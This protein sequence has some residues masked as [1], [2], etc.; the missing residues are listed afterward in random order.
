M[1]FSKSLA[2]AIPFL[3]RLVVAAVGDEEFVFNGFNDS[4]GWTLQGSAVVLPNG[5]LNL[6]ATNSSSV[7]Y[8]NSLAFYPSPFQMRN[9]TDSSTFSFSA[10][11]AF[12]ILPYEDSARDGIAFVIAPNTS[13]TN[14]TRYDYFGLLDREDSGK[15]SNHLAYIELDIWCDREFGDIDNNH[16]GININSLKSSRSSPAGYYMDD[17]FSDLHPLRLSSGKV[18]Q[19][20]ID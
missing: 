18:M 11:F 7:A 2:F 1:V 5:I 9:L 3:L 10:T 4:S 14:V 19:V 20:W 6:G 16:V 17:P 12:A 15:S 8:P 13:F